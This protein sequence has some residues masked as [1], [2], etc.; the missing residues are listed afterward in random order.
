MAVVLDLAKKCK[1]STTAK[2]ISPLGPT[3]LR[4][5]Q[6]IVLIAGGYSSKRGK[7]VVGA[8][9]KIFFYFVSDFRFLTF[10]TF[11]YYFHF[12]QKCIVIFMKRR[13]RYIQEIDIHTGVL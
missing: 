13:F 12:L 8:N 2:K 1:S 3:N 4:T 7:F 11:S 6:H 9:G 5:S 10:L